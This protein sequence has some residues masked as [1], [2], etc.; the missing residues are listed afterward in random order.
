MGRRVSKI[1]VTDFEKFEQAELPYPYPYQQTAWVGILFWNIKNKEQ[2]NIWFIRMPLDER[3]FINVASRDEFLDMV[4][5]RI[6]ERIAAKNSDENELTHALKDNP[7]VFKPTEENMAAF[8]SKSK[9]MLG[10]SPSAYLT[11]LI[12]YISTDD[13]N[14]LNNWQH[15]G[16]QGFT[17]LAVRQ[18]KPEISKIITR[19]L[20][21]LPEKPFCAICNALENE[22]CS[23]ALM[24]KISDLVDGIIQANNDND[25]AIN[26]VNSCIR[27]FGSYT[28]SLKHNVV[29]K[30]LQSNFGTIPSVL[31]MIAAKCWEALDDEALLKLYLEKLSLN[32]SGDTLFNAL[33]ADQMFLP[34]RRD[35]I[36]QIFRNPDRSESLSDSVGS[37][38][39]QMNSI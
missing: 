5:S 6:G 11:D 21:K 12:T 7:Y 17:D 9:Q 32:P 28:G 1:K 24:T 25:E 29:N 16:I 4:L 2:H 30:I 26:R 23:T 20:D 14:V 19:A 37:F 18:D 15:L 35:K 8:H 27:A 39:Q 10:L 22:S 34:G 38:F 31:I 13:A 36:L 3:G 33:I